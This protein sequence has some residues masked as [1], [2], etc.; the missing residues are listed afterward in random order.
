MPTMGTLLAVGVFA[1]LQWL[2][3]I[4]YDGI[5]GLR[6]P[7]HRWVVPRRESQVRLFKVVSV[8]VA[9]VTTFVFL[10]MLLTF[11]TQRPGTAG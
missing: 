8:V 7:W 1:A 9:A 10:L 2:H 6:M 5:Q 4:C 3:V 11:V